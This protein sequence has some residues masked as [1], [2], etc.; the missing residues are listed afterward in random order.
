MPAD[1]PPGRAT[2]GP[3]RILLADD[4]TLLREAMRDV[5]ATEPDFA[6]VGEASDGESVV[7]AAVRLQPDV[8]LLDVEMPLSV[9]TVTVAR[10]RAAASRC[11]ILVLTMH[12]APDLVRK[13]LTSGAAGY[14][15]KSISRQALAAAIR[16][17]V[18]TARGGSRRLVMS[19]SEEALA[20]DGRADSLLTRREREVLELVAV[21][22][23]NRQVASR[24]SITEA[25][26]K[27]HLRNIFEKLEAVSR[28]DAVN[29]AGAA[30]L[31]TGVRRPP[32][33]GGAAAGGGSVYS[34]SSR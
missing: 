27:R 26:V 8:V 11:Q 31:I 3:I 29:R 22:L 24:L 6:V 20:L 18:D 1:R 4:H 12:D 5:L 21:A 16:G 30:G 32:A 25:T 10:L 2:A 28:I 33:G 23:S 34:G 9:P 15:H 19:V 13:M 7:A 14:L 17:A